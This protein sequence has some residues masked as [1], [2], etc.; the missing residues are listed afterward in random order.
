M[1]LGSKLTDRLDPS[2]V[3][4]AVLAQACQ[5]LKTSHGCI[6]VCAPYGTVLELRLGRGLFAL[7]R[8]DDGS[9]GQDIAD[10]VWRS[11][12]PLVIAD[13]QAWPGRTC[14]ATRGVRA[15]AGVPLE[16]GDQV[17]GVLGM[18]H[19]QGSGRGFTTG[20][21]ELLSGLAQI[22]AVALDHARLNAEEQRSHEEAERLRAA[23]M[24]LSSSLDVQQVLALILS[25]LQRVVPHDSASV[26]EL[27]GGKL[28]IVGGHGFPSLP[29]ILAVSFDTASTDFP[30]REVVER[31]APVIL[32]DA[33][34]SYPLLA[35]RASAV[36]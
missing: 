33:P 2:G 3:L 11:G 19:D 30:N 22:A 5:L 18:A 13:Y 15:M 10:E 27:R 4:D 23:M 7:V 8:D 14:A 9:P 25:E 35:G 36:R 32:A 34:A 28:Q 24:A 12:R 16:H 21:I 31:R 29:E 20:D 17:V 26:Q 6:Y 1:P